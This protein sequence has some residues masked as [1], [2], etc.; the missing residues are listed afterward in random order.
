[1]AYKISPHRSYRRLPAQRG[2]LLGALLLVGALETLLYFNF[3]LLW[4]L[5]IGAS[6]NLLSRAGYALQPLELGFAGWQLQGVLLEVARWEPVSLFAM[7]L[8]AA[9]GLLLVIQSSGWPLLLRQGLG[10][11]AAV[12]FGS[13]LLMSLLPNSGYSAA[14][15]SALYFQSQAAM[16]LL[17]LPLAG[18]AL[19]QIPQWNYRLGFVLVSFGYCA[20]L[21][22]MRLCFWYVALQ[23]LGSLAAPMLLFWFGSV[24]D[25][26]VLISLYSWFLYSSSQQLQKRGAAWRWL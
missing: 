19:V 9:L 12:V 21:A 6:S 3:P 14:Q 15:L 16:L 10:L 20:V 26:L 13:S 18:L 7:G 17:V 2:S 22:V 1:M 4:N 8:V 25:V 23:H 24:L 11:L 5:L